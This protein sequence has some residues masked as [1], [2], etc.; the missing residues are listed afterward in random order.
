MFKGNNQKIWFDNE[1]LSTLTKA[2]AKM[3]IDY[4]EIERKRQAKQENCPY[5]HIDKDG[6]Y[7][8]EC[9]NNEDLGVKIC[10]FCGNSEVSLLVEVGEDEK[11]MLDTKGKYCAYCGRQLIIDNEEAEE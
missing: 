4:E 7:L 6:N 10:L 1:L 2:E 11:V 5:C 8:Q 3:A 9:F